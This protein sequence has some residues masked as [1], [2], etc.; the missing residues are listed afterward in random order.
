MEE[1]MRL[2]GFRV[3]N[4]RSIEDSGR[5]EVANRTALV[6]R[7]ESGK[8][9]LLLALAA[10]NPPDGAEALNEV[11]DLP[12]ERKLSDFKADMP[13]IETEWAL[14]DSEAEMLSEKCPSLGGQVTAVVGQYYNGNRWVSFPDSKPVVVDTKF[15]SSHAQQAQKALRAALGSLEEAVV[16]PVNEAVATLRGKCEA[17]PKDSNAWAVAVLGSLQA[18]RKA[19]ATASF[20][21][22]E[23]VETPLNALQDY[24][25]DVQAE[26]ERKQ[27]ARNYIA[28]LLPVFMFLDDYPELHGHQNLA[29]LV[30]RLDNPKQLTAADQN[31][32]KLMKVAGLDPK[33]LRQLLSEGAEKRQLLTNRASATVTAK[34]RELWKDRELTVRFA[35]DAE[36]FDTLVSDPTSVFPVE[37][38]LDER[39]RGFRWFFSF[40]ITFAADT[41][42]GP[43]EDAVLLL[44]EPGLYLHA[45]AQ[46][47][48]LRLFRS[49]FKNQILYTTHSPFMIPVDELSS[50]RTVSI[51]PK[52]G[53]TVANDP[54]GDSRT[55]FPLQA[56]LGYNIAQ[57]LFVGGTNIVV[58]GV[59]DFWYLSAVSEQLA[60]Q[61]RAH[62]PKDA[63]LTPVGG[64][65]KVSYMVALLASQALNVV[66]LLDSEKEAR[67]TAAELAKQKL[68]RDEYIMFV[69]AAFSPERQDADVED[70]LDPGIYEALVRESYSKELAGKT[71]AP[72]AN[73]PRMVKRFE[74]AF[75]AV[76][77][78]FRKTRPA[79]LFLR[80]LAA[81][82]NS[83]LDQATLDRFAALFKLISERLGK[84]AASGNGQFG[85]PAGK[86]T[87]VGV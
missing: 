86:S 25:E 4:F 55:L 3:M 29:E 57:A 69:G 26:K 31:F 14:T 53:T 70:L 36:Y 50:I 33:L 84:L 61:N 64:A 17:P 22:P 16:K 85:Y 11:K 47:D 42:G 12:R 77:L 18:L 38:N 83:V 34:I 7:N 5:I 43:A 51:A 41:Q 44:D 6:G 13:F 1:Q 9:N 8:T 62:L 32:M 71:L 46:D 74:E 45:L 27:E 20:K 73:I 23:D 40:F 10:L 24:C 28:S 79:R 15:A 75:G 63:T 66:V 21:L 68:I 49:D 58:E 2:T 87:R 37:V 19:A 60:A 35:L 39:S 52:I 54:M 67:A 59:T 56:A 30:S 72:N 80:K 76:G 65:Q 81:D 48:L 82:P 78:E